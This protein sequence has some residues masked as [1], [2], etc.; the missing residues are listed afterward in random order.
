MNKELLFPT[1]LDDERIELLI[2]CSSYNDKSLDN[3]KNNV[4]RKISSKG[5]RVHKKILIIAAVVMFGT[6]AVAAA[7]NHDAVYRTLFGEHAAYMRNHSQNVGV[8]AEADGIE[9][10][11]LSAF[12]YAGS[13]SMV[14]SIRDKEGD[15]IDETTAFDAIIDLGAEGEVLFNG[16]TAPDE[17]QSAFD[18]ETGEFICVDTVMLPADFEIGNITYTVT[19]LRSRRV[20]RG[21]PEGQIDLYGFVS[22]HT[23]TTVVPDS[24]EFTKALTPE[25]THISFSDVDWSYISNLGFVDGSLHIQIKDDPFIINYERKKRGWLFPIYLTD[26]DG[27]K[28][29][30][31]REYH[32]PIVRLWDKDSGAYSE[33]VFENIT[34]ATQLKGMTLVKEGYE[35]TE[36]MGAGWSLDEHAK[37][38]ADK[39][40]AIEAA[41]W[42]LKFK[43]SSEG[44]EALTIPVKKE[45]PVVNG[46]ELY[47][48]DIVVTP[49][50][51]NVSYLMDDLMDGRLFYSLGIAEGTASFVLKDDPNNENFITYDD[52]TIFELEYLAE[53]FSEYSDALGT[54][55][56]S[57]RYSKL[58][59]TGEN[60]IET[61]RIKSVTI[62]GVEFEVE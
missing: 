7:V 6:G 10:G 30:P 11:M 20:D 44:A 55:E 9:V 33:Y 59:I 3:I 2:Q 60:I 50:Y 38:T 15:R 21:G 54:Y 45:I 53:A 5:K 16:L 28:Y 35:Y 34:D 52:G 8:V 18:E 47:A 61:D 62:Q 40:R 27:A 13:L 4:K 43:M 37:T 24:P 31:N 22:K 17:R 23:P 26:S 12:H 1:E 46:V 49:L 36:T 57:V 51:V 14:V 48:D 58:A 41:G 56:A 32:F 19:N 29:E 42:S 39:R 25:E